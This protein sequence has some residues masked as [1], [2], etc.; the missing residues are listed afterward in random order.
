MGEE[1]KESGI[2]REEEKERG[3][4]RGS[5]WRT[6]LGPQEKKEEREREG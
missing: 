4:G 3:R 5:P 1:E 2:G 6:Q